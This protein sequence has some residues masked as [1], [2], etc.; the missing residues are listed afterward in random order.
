MARKIA[1]VNITSDIRNW[2]EGELSR[3]VDTTHY[4]IKIISAIE[5]NGGLYLIYEYDD[6]PKSI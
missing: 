2:W 6:Q 3:Y 1:K 4:E 5:Y